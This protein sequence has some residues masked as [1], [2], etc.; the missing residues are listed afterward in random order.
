[1]ISLRDF[2]SETEREYIE[3]VLRRTGWNVTRAAE[4]LDVQRTHLHQRMAAL[5]ITRASGG[6]GD[7]P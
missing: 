4:L 7:E 2:K 3:A 6:D 1:V 5:G